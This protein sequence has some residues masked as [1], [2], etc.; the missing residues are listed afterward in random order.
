M[1]V[2]YT[3]FPPNQEAQDIIIGHEMYSTIQK[4]K[5]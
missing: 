3:P 1:F 2:K 5:E 4:V